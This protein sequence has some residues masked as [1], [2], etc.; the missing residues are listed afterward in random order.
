MESAIEHK[1]AEMNSISKIIFGKKIWVSYFSGL[2][3]LV[4]VYV[5]KYL[6]KID[7]EAVIVVSVKLFHTYAAHISSTVMGSGERHQQTWRV[8]RNSFHNVPVKVLSTWKA[9]RLCRLCKTQTEDKLIL[10]M[11][12]NSF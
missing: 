9:L 7:G 4:N 12:R 10:K 1:R 5:D 11:S 2:L 6:D 8:T 3:V